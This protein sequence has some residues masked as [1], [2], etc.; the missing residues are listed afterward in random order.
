MTRPEMNAAIY[1]DRPVT[2]TGPDGQSFEVNTDPNAPDYVTTD[3]V[4]V[5]I[6]RK[7]QKTR[8]LDKDGNQVGPVHR[9]LVPAIVWAR[10][11][12]WRN[13]S[14]PDWWNDAVIADVRAGGAP[15]DRHAD[16]G[17]WTPARGGGST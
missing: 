1:V 6:E 16:A 4:E 3:G 13:P 14:D 12:G 11:E 7:H 17:A 15:D 9:N 5:W 10:N 2:L 8:F